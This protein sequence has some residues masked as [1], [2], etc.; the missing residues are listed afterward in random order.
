MRTPSK[1]ASILI[2]PFLCVATPASAATIAQVT[3]I[4]DLDLSNVLMAVSFRP[5]A[6]NDTLE[7]DGTVFIGVTGFTPP[8]MGVTNTSTFVT[9]ISGNT[10]TAPVI[11]GGSSFEGLQLGYVYNSIAV[12]DQAISAVVANGQYQVQ[13]LLAD[14]FGQDRIADITIE[15]KLTDDFSY[16][17]AQLDNDMIGALLTENVVVADGSLNITLAQDG[18]V[19]SPHLSGLII[20]SIP[21]PSTFVLAALG[22]V[23]LGFNRRRRRS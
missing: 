16:A 17:A 4:S 9:T 18:G 19:G 21:E 23:G 15:G 6:T 1:L 14:G 8:K 5:D 7:V 11:S 22:L 10:G 13:L 20:S 12:G 2:V 3:D